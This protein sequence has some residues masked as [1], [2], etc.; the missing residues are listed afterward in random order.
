MLA[1]PS[2]SWPPSADIPAP[3][4]TR[5]AWSPPAL[6]GP[7]PRRPRDAHLPWSSHRVSWSLCGALASSHLGSFL[8]SIY[9]LNRAS[10]IYLFIFI[11]QNPKL[12]ANHNRLPRCEC[13]GPALRVGP[14]SRSSNKDTSGLAPGPGGLCAAASVT[15]SA[16]AS[17]PHL[18]QFWFLG[19]APDQFNFEAVRYPTPGL[20]AWAFGGRCSVPVAE[21]QAWSSEGEPRDQCWPQCRP[22]HRPRVGFDTALPLPASRADS[23]N[24]TQKAF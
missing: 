7:G 11:F 10:G 15:A 13:P 20:P 9:P 23:K 18:L 1:C 17:R 24:D 12:F 5:G 21:P 3:S 8:F 2:G 22:A 6:L 16:K 14:S 19:R 4:T